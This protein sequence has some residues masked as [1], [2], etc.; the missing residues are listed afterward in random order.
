MLIDHESRLLLAQL[1]IKV[2]SEYVKQAMIN[3][4]QTI[5]AKRVRTITPDHST[6]FTQYQA[7]STTLNDKFFENPHA[8][9]QCEAKKNINNLIR[10]YFSKGTIK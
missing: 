8:L 4:L 2:N 9:H 10:K 1:T 6:K 3:L 5:T 7:V